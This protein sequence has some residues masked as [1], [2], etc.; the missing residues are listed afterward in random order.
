MSFNR[1]NYDSCSY[2]QEIS[3]SVGPGE[4]QL[5]TPNISCVDCFAVDPQLIM[6][7]AGSSVSKDMSMIDV[8]SE[9]SNLNRKLTNCSQKEFI[10]KFDKDGNIDNSIEQVHF[11]NCNIPTRENTRLSNPA[12]NLRGTGIN[13][14]EWLC[15]DPQERVLMPFE[16]NVSNRLVVKDN[17]RPILAKPIDQS[18]FLP[19]DNNEPIKVNIAKAPSVPISTG[20]NLQTSSGVRNL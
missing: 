2:K 1:L 14:F 11:E 12:C 16:T 4:Y 5:G 6:Q 17:H 19:V 7:R 18:I 15:N 13:R 20:V 3:E 9:L 8:D 10:P